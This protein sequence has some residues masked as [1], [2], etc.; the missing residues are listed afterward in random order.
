MSQF[1]GVR[2]SKHLLLA[3]NLDETGLAVAKAATRMSLS[4]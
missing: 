4:S 3:P 1:G 2:A